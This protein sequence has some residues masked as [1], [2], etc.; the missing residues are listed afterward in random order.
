[1]RAI[2]AEK[3][4]S[5]E[6]LLITEIAA[7]LPGMGEVAVDLKAAAVNF[8]DLLVVEGKYQ[9]RPPLP[10]VPGKEAAGIVAALGDGV[11]GLALGDRVMVQVEHGAFA[12]RL[13]A[14]ASHCFPI[15]ERMSFEEAAALPVSLDDVRW[16]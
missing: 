12:E 13:V 9:I 7:P 5:P 11:D 8:A 6:D 14:P 16:D 4:G 10:F 2:V 15:P 1:M 3:L